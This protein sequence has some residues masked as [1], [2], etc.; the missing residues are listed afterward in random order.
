MLLL[1]NLHFISFQLVLVGDGGV[2][3][4]TFVKRHMTGEFEKKYVGMYS[5]CIVKLVKVAHSSILILRC[6]ICPS[7]GYGGK[8]ELLIQ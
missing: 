8:F 2:G 4:T 6:V 5:C 7:I 3:K 1:S